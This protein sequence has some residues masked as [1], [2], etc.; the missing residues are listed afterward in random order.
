[1]EI[2]KK[3][4]L[5]F[6]FVAL[7]IVS[8]GANIYFI[9]QEIA[10]QEP[11][12][13]ND[14]QDDGEND[15]DPDTEAPLI[16]IVGLAN[17]TYKNPTQHLIIVATDSSNISS[18]WYN[19]GGSNI[20]YSK[21]TQISLSEGRNVITAWANDSH[22]NVGFTT[23]NL[24]LRTTYSSQWNTTHMGSS[25]S[26]QVQLP[27][28]PHGA[29]DFVVDWGDGTQNSISSW[30][31]A[32]KCHTYSS[33]GTY[34][35]NITG[36]CD[37]W[38]FYSEGDC[39]KIENI[40][41]WGNLKLGNTGS[42]F[43]GCTN[44]EISATDFLDISNIVNLS[45][46]FQGCRNIGSIPHIGEWDTSH[47][48]DMSS[49]FEDAIKFNGDIGMWDISNVKNLNGMFKGALSFNQNICNWDVSSVKDMNRMFQE[50]EVFNNSLSLW[51]VSNVNDMSYMFAHASVF[52][53]DI[54]PWNVSNVNDMSYMFSQA[55]VFKGDISP[56]NVSNVNDMSYMFSQASVF[57]GN[58]STWNV[59]NVQKMNGMFQEAE[60]F[61]KNLSLWDVSNVF[62]MS[63]MFSQASVF[64]GNVSTWNVSNVIDM[65]YMFSEATN[66]N[67]DISTWNVSNVQKLNNMFQ[68][69]GPFN[70]P[71]GS[72][73]PK[74]CTD[75]S[76]MFRYCPMF[77][78]N[79][80]D[81]PDDGWLSPST[82]GMFEFTSQSTLP[83]WI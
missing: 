65:S 22:G 52:N 15:P 70:Q 56:W 29:Y 69:L 77:D 75:M 62:N 16:E 43:A 55:S 2:Q 51:D 21:Y 46:T 72:W 57:N 79:L 80:D 35:I 36:L 66:F 30:N 4:R 73:R 20:S 47:I 39:E 45:K 76:Y 78:Q 64:N 12:V 24:Y 19:M 81:W 38:A 50:A 71:L 18:I 74:S 41:Q 59:S 54:S 53:G 82:T 33:S 27:L 61:N 83:W 44:L 7:L 11:P 32:E 5:T 9:V 23:L 48:N 3:N 40:F 42:Y 58:V 28:I 8:L 37:G 10:S 26:N 17:T 25:G 63:Y 60:V 1:M 49:L 67:E 68:F 13:N 34:T 6:S 31:Q 14:N